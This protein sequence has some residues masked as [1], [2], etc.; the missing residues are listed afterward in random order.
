MNPSS[1]TRSNTTEDTEN[2]IEELKNVYEVI[3]VVDTERIELDAYQ[4]KG[5]AKH[6][7][8]NRRMVGFRMHH[9]EVG[10]ASRK[11][12]CGGSFLVNRR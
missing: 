8:I 5:V 11:P 2:F 12:S 1:F 4:L 7:L 10:L 9:I 3:H 6:G